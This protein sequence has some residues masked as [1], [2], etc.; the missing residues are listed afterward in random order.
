MRGERYYLHKVIHASCLRGQDSRSLVPLLSETV[1]CR[2]NQPKIRDSIVLT[3][4]F[5]NEDHPCANAIWNA[6][7]NRF[8]RSYAK[9][10]A[11]NPRRV[12]SKAGSTPTGNDRTKRRHTAMEEY[13]LKLDTTRNWRSGY[14]SITPRRL[15]M[16]F[17][18][19]IGHLTCAR[20]VHQN[21]PMKVHLT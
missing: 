13:S 17:E 1:S 5:L 4:I 19:I 3:S 6:I 10:P 21:Q 7:C 14:F 20:A 11:K 8:L 12:S 9:L 18:R 2:E 15:D 16:T